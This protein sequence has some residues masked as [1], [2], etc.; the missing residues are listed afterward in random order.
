MKKQACQLLIIFLAFIVYFP[1]FGARASDSIPI[2]SDSEDWHIILEEMAENDI[3]TE[4]L[5][6]TLT[7][8][9]NN[10]IQLNNASREVLENIPILN[11]EQVENLSY[12]LYRY[13]PMVSLS[14][15][16]L[17]EGMDARTM[18]W[19]KPFV[20]LG[21]IEES[22]VAYPPMKKALQYGKQEVRWSMGSTFQPKEG[23]KASIDSSQR[24]LGDPTHASF[25]YDF[26]Y[27]DQLQWGLVMEKDPGE[28]WWGEK[29][30]GVDYVSLFILIKD[31]KH[32]N[33][34]IAGDYNIRFGQGLICGSSFSLG[35]NTSGAVPEMTGPQISRHFSTSEI[36]F[37]RGVA[38]RLTLKPYFVEKGRRFGIDL[39]TF[40][41]TKKLDSDVEKG[42]FSSISNTGLH[43]TLAEVEIKQRLNQATIGG[44][45][46]F[47]WTNLIVGITS[48]GWMYD[49]SLLSSM[50]IWRIFNIKGNKGGNFSIDF[51]TVWKGVLAFGE[52]ALDQNAHSA[53]LVGAAFKPFPRMNVSILGRKYSPKYQ[54]VFSNAFS[55]GTKANNEEGFFAATDVQLAKRIMLSGYLDV[56]RFPWL[57]YT[58]RSPSWGQDLAAE[59]KM[60]VG[61]NGLV[62]LFVKSKTKE[63]SDTNKS[64]PTQ[65]TQT[66]LKNQVRL[67]VTQKHGLWTM[68]SL[69]YANTYQFENKRSTGFAVAQDLGL[70]PLDNKLSLFFHVVL[71][72]TEAWDNKIYLWEKD[73]PGAFSMPMLYGQGFRTSF[74]M[75]YNLK[76][77]SL[78]LK[79]SDYV[80]PGINMMGVGLEQ[81]KGDRSTEA[82][83]QLSWKF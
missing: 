49:A 3:Q 2:L 71:F 20:C 57:G 53:L 17:I 22:P 24:Y 1:A 8:L 10:P 42:H 48:L 29:N 13:G 25:R 74:F 36:N 69:L 30:T 40:I 75:R 12:Y 77:V 43:R 11:A 46:Q 44:H 31:S 55:E 51:R 81:I 63:K 83:F 62:K 82:R 4:E 5:E 38:T 79:I 60:T 61:R 73:L 27:K 28:Q 54:A 59:I 50:E 37:F 56:F 21:T 39:S 14:E 19:L 7:E 32:K 16:L 41:S 47:R 34:L 72:N 18:R 45:L 70:E 65:P 9:A 67:Q 6:E 78:Q 23:Y 15:I 64:F 68:K 76:N 35:K 52:F 66:F 80:Q 26:D 58:V 33:T